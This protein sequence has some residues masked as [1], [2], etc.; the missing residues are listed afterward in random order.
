ME[1]ELKNLISIIRLNFKD[2][3]LEIIESFIKSLTVKE[4]IYII[5]ITW[6]TKNI[7]GFLSKYVIMFLSLFVLWHLLMDENQKLI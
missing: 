2:L 1:I 6:I 3:N 5:F 7:L 4:I